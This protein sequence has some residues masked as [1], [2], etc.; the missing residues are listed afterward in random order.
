[1]PRNRTAVTPRR[2]FIREP[3]HVLPDGRIIGRNQAVVWVL[4]SIGGEFWVTNR[5]GRARPKRCQRRV[6]ALAAV[7]HSRRQCRLRHHSRPGFRRLACLGTHA[8]SSTASS[9]RKCARQLM[10][11]AIVRGL[12]N[13]YSF[14]RGRDDNVCQWIDDSCLRGPAVASASLADTASL[15]DITGRSIQFYI[16]LTTDAAHGGAS[17]AAGTANMP[18]IN[19]AE[20]GT[21]TLG[22]GIYDVM[23]EALRA[24]SGAS[25]KPVRVTAGSADNDFP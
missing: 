7:V 23:F 6:S 11:P 12:Q 5:P 18:A 2:S 24:C 4:W 14:Q 22:S 16:L 3:M 1:M 19:G 13:R 25:S 8:A 9:V 21:I 20:S 17:P 15:A 10:M